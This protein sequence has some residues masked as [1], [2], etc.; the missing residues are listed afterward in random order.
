M[1]KTTLT[2]TLMA[3]AAS[4]PSPAMGQGRVSVS[5][6]PRLG[7]VAPDTY[8]YEQFAN[9]AG[10]GPVEWTTGSLGR[11]YVGGLG[12]ELRFGERGFSVRAEVLRSFDGWL[13]AT[14]GV[15]IPRVLFEPPQIVNTFLDVPFTVTMTSVQVVLPTK[16]EVW[17]L[18]PYVLVGVGGK[19]YGFGE[20]TR[21]NDVDATLPAEG[22]TWGGDLGGGVTLPLLGLAVDL[23][24]RD[25]ITKYW[26]KTQHDLVYSGGVVWRPW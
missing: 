21:P 7:L 17:R 2:S 4:L 23:Q 22:F 15:V 20:P 16:L 5:V 11:A 26:G 19:F 25:A 9:F 18:Q 8:F 1:N 6:V 13:V 12:V 14:H 3:L 10:D 24:V